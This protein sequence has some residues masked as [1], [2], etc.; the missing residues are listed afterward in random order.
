MRGV[1]GHWI[2]NDTLAM[3]LS[4]SMPKISELEHWSMST[5]RHVGWFAQMLCK[6]VDVPSCL[7]A[8]SLTNVRL[9]GLSD[10]ET[11]TIRVGTLYLNAVGLS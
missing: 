9:P 2:E 3:F 6:V 7:G 5:H 10:A 4:G 8:I 1:I 11:V